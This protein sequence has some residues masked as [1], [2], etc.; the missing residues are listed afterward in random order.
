MYGIGEECDMH[1]LRRGPQEANQFLF[2]WFV[3][4]QSTPILMQSHSSPVFKTSAHKHPITSHRVSFR[5]SFQF[6]V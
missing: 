3:Q 2:Q 6:K 1:N 5:N 4:Q